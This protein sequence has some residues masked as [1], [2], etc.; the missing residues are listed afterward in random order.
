[1]VT[2]RSPWSRFGRYI[3]AVVIACF[4][5]PFFGVSCDDMDVITISGF[6]MVI[7]AKPGGLLVEAGK[8]GNMQGGE[9]KI[10]HVDIEP[11]A[12]VALV[13]V[14]ACLGV[15]VVRKRWSPKAGLGLSIAAIGV[16]AGLYVK[17][18]GAMGDV[19]D[20]QNDSALGSEFAKDVKVSAGGRMG[21]YGAGLGLLALAVLA[22]RSLNNRD[23]EWVEAPPPS[24]PPPS[25]DPLPP[26]PVT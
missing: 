26:P 9:L 2:K 1:M 7:G 3:N 12:I 18:M 14:V 6:D 17:V 5:L 20:K 21:L 24:A 13:L 22:G 25:I 16:L 19:I 8:D 15:S 4:F 23:D 11:L 10:D